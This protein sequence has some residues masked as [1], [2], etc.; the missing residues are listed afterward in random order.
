MYPG[1]Q[2]VMLFPP[3]LNKIGTGCKVDRGLA[4]LADNAQ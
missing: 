4:F 3:Q 1:K 2:S